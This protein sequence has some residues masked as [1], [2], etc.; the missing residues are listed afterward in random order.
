[1]GA[2]SKIKSYIENW[3]AKGYQEGI[4]D[5]APAELEKRGLVPSYK[6]ICIAIMK[7]PNNL[8]SL[9]FARDKCRIYQE[10]KREEIYNRNI[11]GKQYKLFL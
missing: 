2:K 11:K 6:M 7:N 4:P 3:E 9:G 8:E 10:I 1:M 5:E